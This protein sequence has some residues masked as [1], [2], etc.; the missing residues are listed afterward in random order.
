M[1]EVFDQYYQ[2]V[3]DTDRV[4]ALECVDQALKKGMLVE[5]IV[6]EIVVPSLQKMNEDFAGKDGVTLSQHFICVSVADEIVEKL[7]PMFEKPPV[8]NGTVV[9]GTAEDD[10]HGLGKKIVGGCLRANMY[11][12]HDIGLNVAAETFVSQAKELGASVIGISSMM[13]HTATGEN[14]P[15]RVSEIIRSEGLGSSLRVIVG[16]APYLFDSDLYRTVGA[17][18]WAPD[19]IAAVEEIKRLVAEVSHV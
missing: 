1:S 5:E 11:T 8:S 2:A 19:G 9:I 14:G 15:R 3:F 7:L 18:S 4:R 16:G 10:F 17:D 12:V 13:V 6:F